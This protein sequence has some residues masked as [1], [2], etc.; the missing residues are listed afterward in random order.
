MGRYLGIP[1]CCIDAFIAGEQVKGV[2]VLRGPCRTREECEAADRAIRHLFGDPECS[3]ATD[4]R[5]AHVPCH[6][7]FVKVFTGTHPDGWVFGEQHDELC[8]IDHTHKQ[9]AVVE[10][11]HILESRRELSA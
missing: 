1:D 8:D 11:L 6:A 9:E 7:C 4:P 3:I 2:T 5:R 10:W